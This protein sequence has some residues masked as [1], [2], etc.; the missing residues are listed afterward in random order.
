[1]GFRLGDII[2]DRIQY[3]LAEDFDGNLLYILTQ[4][5]DASIEISSE[6]KDATDAQGNLVKRFFQAKTGTFTANNAFL[7]TSILTAKSGIP[8]EIAGPG[9][10]AIA[11]PKIITAKAGEVIVVEGIVDGSVKVNAFYTNGT[12]GVG[13]DEVFGQ[14]T[15]ATASTFGYVV[16]GDNATITLPSVEQLGAE[17]KEITQFVVKYERKVEEG[18][19]ILNSADKFPGTI[20]LTLKALCVDPCTADTLRACY[21]VLPS[22]Q[23]SPDL[24]ISLTTDGQLEYSGDLQVDYCST[25]KALFEFYLA[26]E[27]EEE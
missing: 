26:S 16:E 11:M 19:R 25:E 22:F 8:A 13:K 27:D 3:G 4:L 18:I 1:M 5:A 15:E 7:N 9:D 14:G 23:V 21:I 24:S 2:I 20:K 12:M 10:E 17:K 6:T